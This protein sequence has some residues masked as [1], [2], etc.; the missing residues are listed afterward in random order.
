[1][2]KQSERASNG[3]FLPSA[4]IWVPETWN[5]GFVDNKGR[6]RVFR[7][8]CPRAYKNG[9]ALRAHVVWWLHH[10]ATHDRMYELH[11]KDHNRLN[12]AIDNLIPLTQSAHASLHRANLVEHQCIRCGVSFKTHAWRARGRLI[13]FCSKK[14]RDTGPRPE[15]YRRATLA[16][17]ECGEQFVVPKHKKDERV[18]CSNSCSA[19]FMHRQRRSSGTVRPSSG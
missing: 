13:K 5:S 7:P 19:T 2:R 12:D 8:D 9:W 16:C 11:H 6:F 18:F 15:R 17:K 14:C 10:G 3:R 1:M 4:T